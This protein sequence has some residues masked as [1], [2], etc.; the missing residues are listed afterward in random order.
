MKESMMMNKSEVEVNY[1]VISPRFSVQNI[2]ELQQGIEHLNERGYAIFSDI[3]TND[4]INNSID[5]LW[6]HLE[7]LKSPYDIRRNDPE[8]WNEHWP[9]IC[10][11]GLLNDHGIGQSE[12]MWYIRGKP[13]VKKVF[14]HIWNSNELFTS[15]DGVGCFRDWNLNKKWKT[16]SAWYHCDQNPFR[17][18]DRCSIQGFVSLTDNDE[19]TGGL[20]IVPDSHKNFI[21]L[22]FILDENRLWGDFVSIPHEVMERVHPRLVKCKAGDLVVWDSRCI[23]CNTPAL[24]DKRKNNLL[25]EPQLLRIV[26]YICMS[27]LS[28]FEPDGV[29]YE[30]LEEF[31]ELRENFV[32]NRTT[33]THWPLELITASRLSDYDKV[34]LKLNA[35]QHSLIVGTHV[36]PENGTTE[37][38]F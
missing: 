8:T 4:E 23:H 9:G 30:N 34:P 10:Y 22:Q 6:K 29:R 1:Q 18:P 26:A 31:R 13:N 27:P 24:H 3:L 35:Y 5:L 17:K 14:S 33:C 15:F 38:I 11:I 37:I 21:D 12:F 28:M 16:D 2:E 32:R 20:V 7:N 25:S 36:E 19:S